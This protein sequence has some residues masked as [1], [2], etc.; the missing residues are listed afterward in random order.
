MQKLAETTTFTNFRGYYQYFYSY[1]N[2]AVS[3][4]SQK[5]LL[6][7]GE[8]YYLEIFQVN[9]MFAAGHLTVSLEIPSPK[10]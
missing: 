2:L 7:A 10:I 8:Y 9:L 4:I 3:S 6:T 5:I 1:P